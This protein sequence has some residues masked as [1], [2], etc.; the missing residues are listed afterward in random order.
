IRQG[1]FS[2]GSRRGVPLLTEEPMKIPAR[3][4][5]S[6][7]GIYYYRFQFTAAGK[8]RERRVSLQTKNPVV[9]REKS[10]LVS[11]ILVA[12][13][14]GINMTDQKEENRSEFRGGCMVKVKQ[15]YRRKCRV[16]CSSLP[17]PRPAGYSRWRSAGAY[18]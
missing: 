18:G 3:V 4:S 12:N 2:L 14:A 7:H 10:L 16:G 6:R 8:R 1:L 11:A 13:K 15:P 5:Q 17:Q 9:A